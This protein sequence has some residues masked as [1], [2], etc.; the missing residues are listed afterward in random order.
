MLLLLLL[1]VVIVG[2]WGDERGDAGC[3][4]GGL[5]IQEVGGMIGGGL[6]N[7]ALDKP[8][9]RMVTLRRA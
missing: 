2:R 4:G 3:G 1:V 8:V 6:E 9:G 7:D 5:A